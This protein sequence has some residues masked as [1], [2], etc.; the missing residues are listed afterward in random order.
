MLSANKLLGSM[1][2]LSV[3]L[4]SCSKQMNDKDELNQEDLGAKM[5]NGDMP[6]DLNPR[7]GVIYTMSNEAGGNSILAYRQDPNGKLSYQSTSS[8]GGNGNGAGLGSQGSIAIDDQN[9]LFAVNAG[10][11]SVSSFA[12][13]DNGNLTLRHT[14]SSNGMFPVS[15]TVHGNFLYVVNSGSSN[16]SGYTI[17][18][19]GTLTPIP[20]SD[21]PL[22]SANAG[23]AQIAF[24]PGG[25]KLIVTEKSN[26]KITSFPVNNSGQASAGTS[27]NSAGQTPFGFDFAGPGTIVVT[28]ASGGA[29][30]A[31][32]VSSYSVFGNTSVTGGPLAIGQTAAC[33]AAVTSNG[34]YAYVT[35]TG[36]NTISSF[37]VYDNGNI[38]LINAAE[39]ATG[40]TPIDITL[41]SNDF[42]V[43]NL[44]A[45]SHSISVYKKGGNETLKKI[46]EIPGLP[47]HAVGLASF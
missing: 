43:Y 39:V 22:S 34:H 19:Q 25:D 9:R 47:V 36:S 29:P 18:A 37:A 10:S 2:G 5:K 23:P 40:R 7:E 1:I 20:G 41:S 13:S 6:K 12:I 24:T 45:G 44:N 16:I 21:Q 46:E 30:Q 4:L 31:S 14:T 17:G 15:V 11:N 35:N 33:W 26:N 28:E 38:K 42:Y 8:S 3:L 27:V 32:T